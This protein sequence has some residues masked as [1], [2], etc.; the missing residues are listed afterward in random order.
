MRLL[1]IGRHWG[2]TLER[3]GVRGLAGVVSRGF[4]GSLN[5]T[6]SWVELWGKPEDAVKAL[7]G[8]FR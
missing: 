5:W 6:L 2:R 4:G 3:R 1:G 8:R 7:E